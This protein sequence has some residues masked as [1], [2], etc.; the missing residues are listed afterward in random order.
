MS[1]KEEIIEAAKKIFSEYGIEKTTLEDI[2]SKCG[3]KKSSLYH[4]FKNK[5]NIFS[6]VVNSES[7]QLEKILKLG[8][9]K[10]CTPQEKLY[11]HMITRLNRLKEMKH[12]RKIMI[13]LEE[14]SK[15][16]KVIKKE[17]AHFVTLEVGIL[18]FILNEGIEKGVF[19]IESPKSLSYVLMAVLM[20]FEFPIIIENMEFDFNREINSLLNVIFNGIEIKNGK[21]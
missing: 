7:K 4:Y 3:M 5:E 19:R 13:D 18:Q 14:G 20:G 6:E 11:N 21:T 9:E 15:F 8:L 12:Y 16:N 2:G 17:R 1:K 10:K